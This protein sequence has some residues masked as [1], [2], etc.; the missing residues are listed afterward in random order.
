MRNLKFPKALQPYQEILEE[1]IQPFIEI[2][3]QKGEA[4]KILKF[5][6]MVE[7]FPPTAVCC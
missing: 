4:T 1:T 5:L 7:I 6:S 3:A 2:S